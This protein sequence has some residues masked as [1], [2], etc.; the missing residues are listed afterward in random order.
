MEID[1]RVGQVIQG[2]VEVK[3]SLWNHRPV[4]VVQAEELY[5]VLE[6]KTQFK[7]WIK[8]RIDEYDFQENQDFR[9][10]VKNDQQRSRGGHNKKDYE[11]SL[12]MAKELAMVERNDQGRRAGRYFIQCERLL[13]AGLRSQKGMTP[14]SLVS[15]D[16]VERFILGQ[17][18]PSPLTRLAEEATQ[19]RALLLALGVPEAQIPE[20]VRQLLD[21]FCNLDLSRLDPLNGVKNEE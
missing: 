14:K 8:R 16:A 9:L 3:E 20:K 4:L 1:I 18:Q 12:D 17:D 11:L 6:V 7:N 2:L 5:H 10:L 19:G 13:Y 15:P 21:H